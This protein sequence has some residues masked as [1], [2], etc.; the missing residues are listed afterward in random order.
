MVFHVTNYMR[1]TNVWMIR[2]MRW[3]LWGGCAFIPLY[4]TFYWDF[5]GRRVVFKDW[6]RG[7]SEE[8]KKEEAI[9]LRANWG[10][11]PR[12]E[13]V[14]DFSIKQKIHEQ[15][16]REEMFAD[17]PRV[18]TTMSKENKEGKLNPKDVRTIFNIAVEHNRQPGEFNYLFPQTFYSLYPDIEQEAY[19]TIG[20]SAKR[21]VHKEY[22]E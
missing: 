2:K 9:Q 5:I 19:V 7:K 18:R 13:P 6:L 11:K 14:L 22:Q 16:T 1:E 15:Q 12:Y 3:I 4:R 20:G 8:Q 10:Y 17:R 21:K